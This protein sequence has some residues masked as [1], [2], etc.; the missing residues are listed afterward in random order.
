MIAIT[1][2]LFLWGKPIKVLRFINKRFRTAANNSFKGVRTMLS[3]VE[4]GRGREG[5]E[6]ILI[7]KGSE[8][9]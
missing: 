5:E 8:R 7:E 6:D 9:R 3:R 2:F 1:S 4:K